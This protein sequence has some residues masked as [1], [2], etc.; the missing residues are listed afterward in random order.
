MSTWLDVV[1]LSLVCLPNSL[2]LSVVG[3]SV[4]EVAPSMLSADRLT[5]NALKDR[6]L[7][8]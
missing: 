7:G 1:L 4:R 5:A 2:E 6:G 8:L 3:R